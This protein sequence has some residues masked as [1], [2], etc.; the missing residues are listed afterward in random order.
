[1]FVC[2]SASVW[3]SYD[4]MLFLWGSVSNYVWL[5][6]A[7][8]LRVVILQLNTETMKPLSHTHHNYL[9]LLDK[10]R[11]GYSSGGI[12]WNVKSSSRYH[13]GIDSSCDGICLCVINIYNV[14]FTLDVI[15]K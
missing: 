2:C 12:S 13:M 1:M 10:L 3:M 14:W 15:P 4:R 7:Y 5:L 11:G 6:W 9:S 8:C